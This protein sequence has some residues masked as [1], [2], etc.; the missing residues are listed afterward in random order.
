[1]RDTKV[2]EVTIKQ[3]LIILLVVSAIIITGMQI[4]NAR[5]IKVSKDIKNVEDVTHRETNEVAN[6]V[7]TSMTIGTEAHD[8]VEKIAMVA[9]KRNLED[10]QVV[11]RSTLLERQGD[12]TAQQE[13]L[14]EEQQGNSLEAQQVSKEQVEI[15]QSVSNEEQIVEIQQ[16]IIQYK[17]INEIVIS[18]DMNLTERTGIS[19]EDFKILI[20]QVKQDKTKFFYENSDIIYDVCEQYQINEVFF[21]GLIVAES[22]WNI[23]DSH[24]ATHNYI[25]L[26]SKGKL[27]RYSSVEEGME[28][29]VNN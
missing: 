9:T 22:G 14:L 20:S 7:K 12:V 6:L 5:D 27:I 15:Q 3:L 23:V 25:S 26:M 17:A 28:K 16:E 21:C 2:V 8:E 29:I 24:R 1:M 4:N 10:N 18:R 19:K 11:T 13:S